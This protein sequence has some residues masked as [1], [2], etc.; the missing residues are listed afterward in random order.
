MDSSWKRSDAERLMP[1]NRDW[2]HVRQRMAGHSHPTAPAIVGH[3][4]WVRCEM[5]RLSLL[6]QKAAVHNGVRIL[7]QNTARIIRTRRKLR[8]VFNRSVELH[9]I[10]NAVPTFKAP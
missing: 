4:L 5:S 3:E 8:G 6:A 10:V 1:L 2:I 9:Q 7:R